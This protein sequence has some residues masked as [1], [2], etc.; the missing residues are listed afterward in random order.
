M[1]SSTYTTSFIKISLVDPNSSPSKV[2]IEIGDKNNWLKVER[3]KKKTHMFIV[4]LE[5]WRGI[6]YEFS[7]KVELRGIRA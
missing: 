2:N 5:S 3:D 4:T 6:K 1:V 7:F